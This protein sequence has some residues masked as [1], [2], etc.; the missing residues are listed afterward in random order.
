MKKVPETLNEDKK[1]ARKEVI[2][3]RSETRHQTMGWKIPASPR[4]K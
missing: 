2:L 1:L 4:P 3:K